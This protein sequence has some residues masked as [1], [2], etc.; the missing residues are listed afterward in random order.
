MAGFGHGQTIFGLPKT[1]SIES[2]ADIS[3]P[4]VVLDV[5][6][7]HTASLANNATFSSFLSAAFNLPDHA[8]QIQGMKFVTCS[9]AL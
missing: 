9:G 4:T 1:P 5:Q 3:Q 8:F 6:M 7:D 2:L